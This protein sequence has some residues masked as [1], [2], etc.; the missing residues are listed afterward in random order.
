MEKELS[1]GELNYEIA[2]V[3]ALLS[4]E[5]LGRLWEMARPHMGD[6]QDVFDC[7]MSRY[8]QFTQE[9]KDRETA[10]YK[11]Q[12]REKAPPAREGVQS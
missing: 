8:L 7:I 12:I 5:N 11:A 9:E 4:P 2:A 6:Q 10:H 3:L 1:N